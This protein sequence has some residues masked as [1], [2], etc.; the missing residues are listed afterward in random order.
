GC[1]ETIQHASLDWARS[2]TPSRVGVAEPYDRHP[3]L[4][5]PPSRRPESALRFVPFVRTLA[6][7]REREAES[8]DVL[9]RRRARP[10]QHLPDRREENPRVESQ[11][12]VVDVPRVQ[13]GAVGESEVVAA[14]S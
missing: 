7:R 8:I 2:A 4:V 9:R 3:F 12:P 11:A 6:G 1:P 13:G 5:E 14:G 10:P